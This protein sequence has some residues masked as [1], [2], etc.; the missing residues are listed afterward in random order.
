MRSSVSSLRNGDCSSCTSR[1][2]RNVPSNTE[3]PVVLVKSASTTVS[4]SESLGVARACQYPAAAI[5]ATAAA[6]TRMNILRRDPRPSG[7]WVDAL[8]GAATAAVR[9]PLEIF[10]VPD[11]DGGGPSSSSEDC[12]T[13]E[14]LE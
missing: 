13:M 12:W 9:R 11:E 14:R 6:V 1:P 10:L 4:F 3:S 8:E 5:E 2:W 7:P